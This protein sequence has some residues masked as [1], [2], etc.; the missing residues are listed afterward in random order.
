MVAMVV[1]KKDHEFDV[2]G[3]PAS[4]GAR[5]EKAISQNAQRPSAG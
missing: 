2:I 3:T 1:Q 5:P 4:V